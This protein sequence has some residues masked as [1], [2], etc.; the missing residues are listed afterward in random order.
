[1]DLIHQS[2]PSLGLC[3]LSGGGSGCAV[4]L[5]FATSYPSSLALCTS[6]LYTPSSMCGCLHKIQRYLR[7]G[8]PTSAYW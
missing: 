3:S 5:S 8:W 4:L 2:P 7:E 1:M 6:S